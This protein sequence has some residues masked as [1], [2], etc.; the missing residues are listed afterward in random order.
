MLYII[1]IYSMSYLIVI[2]ILY[3]NAS[4]LVRG[5]PV[6]GNFVRLI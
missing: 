3:L 4:N 5:N 6:R 2:K 1:I